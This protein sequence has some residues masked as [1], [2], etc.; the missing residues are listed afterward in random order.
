MSRPK[1]LQSFQRLAQSF[2]YASGIAVMRHP[3]AQLMLHRRRSVEIAN[4]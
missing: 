1:V 4:Y 2:D 3:Q